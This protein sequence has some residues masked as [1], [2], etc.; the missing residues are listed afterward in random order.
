MLE[1]EEGN[2]QCHRLRILALFE[3]DFNQ[4]KRILIG[5]RLTH[6]L[7]DTNMISNMQYGSVPGKQCL[8]A[9]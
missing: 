3:T 2:S 7:A 8:S 4:A 9:A 1:K 5:R 6:H